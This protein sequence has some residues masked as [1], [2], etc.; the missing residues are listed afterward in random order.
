MVLR[1]L[2]VPWSSSESIRVTE[3]YL[4][5]FLEFLRVSLSSLEFLEVPQ[6][7]LELFRVHQCY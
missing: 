7:S 2:E 6:I 1:V 4:E 5:L 3:S